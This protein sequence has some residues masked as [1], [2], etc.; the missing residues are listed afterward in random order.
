MRIS[1]W[2]EVRMRPAAHT[3]ALPF[4]RTADV[5]LDTHGYGCPDLSLELSGF[6]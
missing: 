5:F 3:G 4:L 1:L 2:C 6:I